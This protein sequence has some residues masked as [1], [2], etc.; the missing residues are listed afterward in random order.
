MKSTRLSVRGVPL[1]L[2]LFVLTACGGG[3]G[4]SGPPPSPHTIG[5]TVSGLKGSG[6]LLQDNGGDTLKISGNGNF[7][8]ATS[9]AGGDPFNVTVSTQPTNP[10]QTCTVAHGSGM[11]SGDDITNVAITCATNSFTVGG[12]VSGLTGS[13][14]VL[15]D[16]GAND[17]PVAKN[18]PFT[19][20]AALASGNAYSVTVATQPTNPPQTCVVS[21]GSGTIGTAN[22]PSIAVFCPQVVASFAY[23]V[24]KGQETP[25]TPPT[26]GTISV[27]TINPVS[28]A[29]TLIPGSAV[30]T[31]PIVSSFQFVP[32][33]SFAWALNPGFEYPLENGFGDGSIY[34]Y[35]VDST[36]GLL[37]PVTGSPFYQLDGTSST[38]SCTSQ[39]P[40][41][42]GPTGLG[43]TAYITLAPTGTFGF[44]TNVAT[45]APV[46]ANNS[47][48]WQFTVDPTSGAPNLLAGSS[49]PQVCTSTDL[50]PVTLDP[51]GRFLYT[52]ADPS[53]GNGLYAFSI[54]SATNALTEIAGSPYP[55]FS[56]LVIDPTGRF[57]Y[58]VNVDNQLYGY[59]IN[60]SSGALTQITGGPYTTKLASIAFD[61]NGQFAYLTESDGIYVYSINGTTGALTATGSSVPLNSPQSPLQIDPSGQFAYIIV[62]TGASGL[63]TGIYAFTITAGT[64][65]LVPVSGNP[66]APG[67]GIGAPVRI[68]L[69]P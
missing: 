33:T 62:N 26:L 53:T 21:N 55:I 15:A 59:T 20:T 39:P 7:T 23:V 37:T 9:V 11:V 16:N 31:G 58:G 13:G 36:T 52:V 48:I 56:S 38:P 25:S 10:S 18:G 64:G 22:V 19:F 66:F 65:A 6:L 28:G 5:G 54:D 35:S 17:T 57:A 2:A 44:A 40:N 29:L 3:G 63:G 61:P 42:P 50:S 14:L 67:T 45:G 30:P 1:L 32:H 34:D 27:F 69:P 46:N 51:S 8:F 43:S 12:T 68:S 24:G 47:E 49:I 4:N 41:S 60:A